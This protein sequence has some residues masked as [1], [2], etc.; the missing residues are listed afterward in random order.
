[1]SKTPI[2]LVSLKFLLNTEKQGK[3]QKPFDQ[4]SNK[5]KVLSLRF[6]R[7]SLNKGNTDE[8]NG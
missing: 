8:Q 7:S 5:K 2:G 1:M 3:V 4:K 6:L